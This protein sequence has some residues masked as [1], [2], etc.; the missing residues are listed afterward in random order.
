V[1]L[2]CHSDGLENGSLINS[3]F[4]PKIFSRYHETLLLE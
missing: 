1:L 2:Y 4:V 3:L